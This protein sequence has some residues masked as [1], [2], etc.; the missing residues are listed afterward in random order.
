MDPPL[1]EQI[2]HSH[3]RRYNSVD[4]I[5]LSLSITGLY[6]TLCQS[7][8]VMRYLTSTNGV[9]LKS[10]LKITENGTFG[11]SMYDFLLYV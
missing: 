7:C 10:G 2:D 3:S 9:P 6:I 5:S 4:H 8:I 1:S 11:Y